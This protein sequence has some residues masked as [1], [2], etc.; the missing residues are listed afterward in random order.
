[1]D[2]KKHDAISHQQS[3]DFIEAV[4]AVDNAAM[5]LMIFMKEIKG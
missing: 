5:R 4:G 1:M 2:I 3:G